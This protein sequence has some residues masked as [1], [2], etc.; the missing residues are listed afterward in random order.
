MNR[1]SGTVLTTSKKPPY[2]SNLLLSLA[3]LCFRL[4]SEFKF[5]AAC[6]TAAL[7]ERKHNRR[8][9]LSSI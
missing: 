4:L 5:K 3:V 9:H 2:L 6:I 8:E 1:I 7:L